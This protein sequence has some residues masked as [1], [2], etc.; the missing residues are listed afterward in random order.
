MVGDLFQ[1]DLAYRVQG[2][3]LRNTFFYKEIVDEPSEDAC[4]VLATAFG[5]QIV[6]PWKLSAAQATQFVYIEA[7]KRTGQARHRAR[8]YFFGEFGSA[9]PQALPSNTPV[10]IAIRGDDG[11]NK[12]FRRAQIGG[13]PE[14]VMDE[15]IVSATFQQT[16]KTNI[17]DNLIADIPAGA[18]GDGTWRPVIIHRPGPPPIP[19]F[20]GVLVDATESLVRAPLG[21][22]D[23]RK[24]TPRPSI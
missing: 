20:P 13:L 23:L 12:A 10:T 2:R 24:S 6:T 18:F 5:V 3:A 1:V 7:R 22:A 11:V 21:S 8:N 9:Q 19:P 16:I 15:G 17:A 4:V 14:D